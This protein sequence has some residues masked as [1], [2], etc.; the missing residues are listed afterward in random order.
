MMSKLTTQGSSQNRLCK[1][2]TFTKE[3]GEEQTRNY[4]S[5]DKYQGRYRSNIGNGRMSY[6]GGAQYRQNYRERLQYNRND[7]G[8][9][10][11]GN[12]RGMQNYRGQN[13][14]GGYRGSFRNDNFGRGR[15]R[16]R[17]RQYSGSLR[18]ND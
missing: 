18:R 6:R 16:S 17:E 7:R 10:R 2:K 5:Q 4:Y 8:D 15:S 3:K 1:P 14:R 11:R 13:L 12:F 9:F